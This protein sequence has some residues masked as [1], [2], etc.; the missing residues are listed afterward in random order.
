M[1][2]A[3][4]KNKIVGGNKFD[5]DVKYNNGDK[6]ISF[7]A[8]T[9]NDKSVAKL[10]FF[11][12]NEKDETLT[13]QT[14]H[15]KTDRNLKIIT[16][17]VAT[18]NYYEPDQKIAE[19]N[20][21][22]LVDKMKTFDTCLIVNFTK[23]S[24]IFLNVNTSANN[25][26]IKEFEKQHTNF[27]LKKLDA[28]M[29]IRFKQLGLDINFVN[30]FMAS[31]KGFF[32]EHNAKK[33]EQKAAEQKAA[34]KKA[35]EEMVENDRAADFL[36]QI[37]LEGGVNNSNKL[38]KKMSNYKILNNLI[39]KLNKINNIKKLTT[40]KPV[41]PVKP[42]KPTKPKAV[43]PTKPKAVKPTKPTKQKAVK[44]TKP[45]PTK[46]KPVKPIKPKAVKPT[47]PVKSTKP[48]VAKPKATKKI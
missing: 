39:L 21:N 10:T 23:I 32:D 17:N 43:K 42:V 20:K 26:K 19:Q 4:F 31:V 47:K 2:K 22:L 37:E 9:N 38:S 6:S 8:K 24:Y 16:S 40:P 28:L 36:K 27:N 14:D 5:F 30:K 35:A 13:I 11:F 48:K 46:P 3:L 45:K 25:N 15:I 7:T 12:K 33:A 1:N 44:P 18:A 29:M 34:E 41:K